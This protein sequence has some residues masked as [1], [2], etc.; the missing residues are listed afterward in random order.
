MMLKKI[1]SFMD[2]ELLW[3]LASMGHG[4][5]I[6]IVDRNFSARRVADRTSSKRLIVLPGVDATTAVAGILE[7][8]P[9]DDFVEFPIIHMGPVEDHTLLLDVHAEVIA[10]CCLA[11]GRAINSRAVERA[12]YYPLAEASFAV[13]QTAEA[14]PYA[15]FILKK[16]VVSAGR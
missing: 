14:R 15:N 12:A 11:E 13:V 2:A 8:F 9:L 4:D 3:T 1:P 7:L 6:A 5:E 16:G 10:A